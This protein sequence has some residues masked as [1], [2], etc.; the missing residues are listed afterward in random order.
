MAWCQ[1][2]YDQLFEPTDF[3]V[4]IIAQAARASEDFVGALLKNLRDTADNNWGH[5]PDRRAAKNEMTELRE[6]RL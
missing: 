2:Y 3:D 5:L 6:R 4:D 1:L